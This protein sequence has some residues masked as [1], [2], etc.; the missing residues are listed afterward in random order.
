M[1]LVTMA[2]ILP[3]FWFFHKPYAAKRHATPRVMNISPAQ[4]GGPLAPAGAPD[5]GGRPAL[6]ADKIR[7]A[8][9]SVNIPSTTFKIAAVVI[10]VERI[11][12]CLLYC[13]DVVLERECS[14]WKS[15]RHEAG[16]T[17]FW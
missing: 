3:H 2:T 8:L 10:D 16:V 6:P 14:V 17:R 7:M 15:F 4:K 11:I 9:I 13:Y 5:G 12:V 1:A